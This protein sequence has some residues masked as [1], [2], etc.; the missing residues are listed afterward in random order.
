MKVGNRYDPKSFRFYSL[1]EVADM[2][3]VSDRTVRRW[4]E[5]G[6]LVGHRFGHQLRIAPADLDTFV[7]LHREG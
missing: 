4:L 7:K 3:S 2:L 6:E 1:R 5:R